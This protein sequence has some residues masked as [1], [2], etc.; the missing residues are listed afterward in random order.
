MFS[1]AMRRCQHFRTKFNRL[2]QQRFGRKLHFLELEE[3]VPELSELALHPA[4]KLFL[5]GIELNVDRDKLPAPETVPS[6]GEQTQPAPGDSR[7]T[8]A[9]V[10]AYRFRLSLLCATSS[11]KSAA[12]QLLSRAK[13]KPSN[14]SVLAM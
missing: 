9:F 6:D 11:W 10:P 14:A 3:P 12:S 1:S 5:P 13:L 2:D 8:L 7:Q 4:E